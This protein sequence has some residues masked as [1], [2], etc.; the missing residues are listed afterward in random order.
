M[1]FASVCMMPIQITINQCSFLQIIS[2]I[3]LCISIYLTK[4]PHYRVRFIQNKISIFSNTRYFLI[5]IN[6]FIIFAY[7]LLL[8]YPYFSYSM[9]YFQQIYNCHYRSRRLAP[10][11]HKYFIVQLRE[12]SSNHLKELSIRNLGISSSI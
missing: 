10:P 8:K 6:L 5:R 7:V 3:Q 4:V 9:W 1:H 2:R 11:I 12:I